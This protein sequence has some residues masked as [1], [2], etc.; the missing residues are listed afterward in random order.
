MKNQLIAALVGGLIL[1]IWQFISFAAAG[2]HESQMSYTDKQDVLLTA[3]AEANLPEGE[4][5]IPN[6]P[7]NASDEDHQAYMEKQIGQ[8]WATVTYHNS[9]NDRMGSNMARAFIIDVIAAFLLCWL[10]GKMAG[11]DFKTC[12]MASLAVGMIG[13]LSINYLD[14][15]W[16][17]TN[18]LPDLLDA[19]VSW[20][21]VG[22]WLG[23]WLPGRVN[24]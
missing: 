4:Y 19:V 2:I 12:V 5:F 21:L 9:M 7:P 16:F 15:I 22:A 3:M 17:E 20:G 18:S 13:Y 8:P 23:W 11:L 1:F 24:S 14:A 10:L 6:L